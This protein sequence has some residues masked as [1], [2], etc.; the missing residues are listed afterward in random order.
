[1]LRVNSL[2]LC[3][4]GCNIKLVIFKFMSRIDILSISCDI[5]L[6]WM[7]QD[8]TDDQSILVQ[9]MAWCRQATRGR[10]NGRPI[11][12]NTILALSDKLLSFDTSP[13]DEQIIILHKWVLL[14][15]DKYT[16]GLGQ[17]LM[18]CYLS[19]GQVLMLCYLSEGQ[20]LMLC[21]LSEGQVLMLCYLSE[22]Q[23]L[24]LCYLSEGQVLMLCYL[25]E[26]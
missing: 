19:E 16:S 20:V 24:M 22:G 1:M 13:M 21:Y 18:L 14:A 26:G 7:P 4:C 9:V 23:V 25:S 6:S 2:T 5:E 3:R 11:V 17:V 15:S 10:R 8:L 12:R